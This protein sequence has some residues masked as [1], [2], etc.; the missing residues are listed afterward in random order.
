M[1]DA[2]GAIAP[3]IFGCAGL[4]LSADEQAFF[5]EANPLGFILFARNCGE[6]NQVKILIETLRAS[7]GRT[8]APVLIDQ[9]GGRVARLTPPH[10]R[11]APAPARFAEIAEQ[12][13]E[14][15]IQA[16]K[17]NAHLMAAELITLGIT[18]NCTPVIDLPQ[19]GADPIIGDRA[20][21]HEPE[22]VTLLGR[23][24]CEGM[25]DGGVIPVIKHIPG[26]G[27]APADSHKSLP[28][29]ETGIDELKATD[30]MPFR[31]LRDM[32]WA[33][34]A[35]VLYPSIDST[36]PATTSKIIIG[37]IIRGVIDYQGVLVSDDLSM[38]ALSGDMKT[39]TTAS[40]DAGCD[41]VLH[42]NGKRAE[43]ESIMKVCGVLRSATV[44]RLRQA[45]QSRKTPVMIDP[46]EAEAHLNQLMDS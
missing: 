22:I 34:T 40:L 39:R 42:C 36:A 21:G 31:A 28:V 7:V 38:E 18:V 45:E 46:A 27:R 13:P 16:A 26:H 24:V 33:M 25:M 19:P 14:R 32:P 6:P 43:M 3:A 29:V 11:A 9:E 17:L 20:L 10:W 12:S 23:A 2:N 41:L 5:Q 44:Q 8:D 37:D 35:H 4:T 30:F 15:A 1:V